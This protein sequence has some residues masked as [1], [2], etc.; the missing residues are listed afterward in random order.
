MYIPFVIKS[1]PNG[2]LGERFS[3]ISQKMQVYGD[4]NYFQFQKVFEIVLSYFLGL[5]LIILVIL[6]KGRGG[7]RI[8]GGHNPCPLPYF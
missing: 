6:T 3:L 7:L 8:E 5:L 1:E 2:I 4:F